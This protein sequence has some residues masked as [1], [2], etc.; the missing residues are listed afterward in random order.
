MRLWARSACASPL[1]VRACSAWIGCHLARVPVSSFVACC[2]RCPGFRHPVA[3]VAWHLSLCLGCKRWRAPLA[4]LL[5]LRWCAA[6]CLVRSLSVL[7]STFPTQC[8]FSQPSGLAPPDLLGGCAGHVEAGREPGS[9]CLLMAAAEAGAVGSLRVVPVRGPAM[10]SSL[11]G[12][13]GVGLGLRALRW[14]A[15][16]DPITDLSGVPYLPSFDGGLSRCTR[17]VSC[18]HRNHPF[19][20]GGR[21]ARMA[22]VCACACF[23]RQVG[24]AGLPGAFWCASPF[25]VAVFE[26]LLVCSAPS[27]LGFPC[28]WLFRVCCF[29]FFRSFFLRSLVFCFSC[30]PALCALGLGV[31]RDPLRPLFSFFPP[32]FLPP[33][34]VFFFLL[35]FFTSF[36]SFLVP[37]CAGW[38]V[39][40]AGG[41]VR[42][43]VLLWALCFGGGCCALALRRSVLAACP[44]SYCVLACC[45][46]LAWWR[47]A[48]GVALP[49][50]AYRGCRVVL[51][52]PPLGC[53]ARIFFFRLSSVCWLWPLPPPGWLW[54]PLLCFVVRRV[55]W[56]CGRWCVLCCARCCLACFFRVGFLRRVARRGVVLGPVFVVLCCRALLRSLRVFVLR[57]SLSFRGAPGCVCFCAL[58]VWC[59]AGVPASLLSSWRARVI[60]LVTLRKRT[61]DF[62][63]KTKMIKLVSTS[64]RGF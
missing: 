44:S 41:W 60:T 55:V 28:L 62:K 22:C 17:A 19:R 24:R 27:R 13:S 35:V 32:S 47:C 56:W 23:P 18:G 61:S 12:S 31:L 15:F 9:L 53:L 46:A 14:C 2:A 33:P 64:T 26:A 34:S 43:R 30:F 36:L 1:L 38:V 49:C 57:C 59:C 8:C 52:N 25:P 51:P 6:P 29:L 50:T 54:C 16:V 39:L 42:W 4:C 21:H 20:V 7:R 37:W 45:V 3:A 63:R 40:Y 5:A 58:L 48:G 11:A 10:G